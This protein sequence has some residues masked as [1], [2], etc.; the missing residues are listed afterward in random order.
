MK[1]CLNVSRE[2]FKSDKRL[3]KMCA[4][5][6]KHEIVYDAEIKKRYEKRILM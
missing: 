3:N 4:K 1:Y 2:T 5:A 6:E